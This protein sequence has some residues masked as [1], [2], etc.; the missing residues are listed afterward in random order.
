MEYETIVGLEVHIEL[1]TGSKM[2]CSCPVSFG[3][4]P[5]SLTCPICMGLPGALPRINKKAIEYGVKTGLALGGNI[6][7]ISLMD[8]KNYFYPDLPKAYQISQ[9]YYP[10]STQGGLTIKGDTCNSD[11]FIRLHELH[12]EEDAGKLV[13]DEVTGKT[14]VDYNR[15]GVPLIE[16]VTEPDIRS[17]EE[18]VRFL[19][20]LRR[21]LKFIEVSDCRI[22]EGS[23]RVDVNLSVRPVGTNE[24]GTR[25]EMKNLSS[26]KAVSRAIEYEARRQTELITAGGQV[27]ME[28]RRWDENR[29]MTLA[30]RPK[31]E[32]YQYKYF[33]DPDIMPI[34][35]TEEYQTELR[36]KLPELPS[37]IQQKMME[38]DKLPFYDSDILTSEPYLTKLYKVTSKI[39]GSPKESSN[40]I[41]TEFM[42][43]CHSEKEMADCREETLGEII[44]LVINGKISRQAGKEALAACFKTGENPNTY[45]ETHGLAMITDPATI[46]K[47][48]IEVCETCSEAVAEY[49][50]GVGKS[51]GFLMGQSMRNLKNQ[52][53]PALVRKALERF[54]R[55]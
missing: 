5:N 32:A 34:Y 22:E 13:H 1:L 26:L 50:Q 38:C 37:E 14:F 41:L 35:I 51:F 20:L 23:M 11:K 3:R 7:P 47:A 8:R 52:A 19:D 55:S 48:V 49:H 4:T 42:K 46:E 29:N 9:L 54:L 28:T 44:N 27:V 25:T 2:F 45:V 53:D 12:L 33:P 18:A 16:I 36:N 15:C 40:W 31:E 39:T 30:M 17:G 10:I 24:L 6:T 43:I 21:T